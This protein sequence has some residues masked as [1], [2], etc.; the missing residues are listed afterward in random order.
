MSKKT[1]KTEKPISRKRPI[2]EAYAELEDAMDVPLRETYVI[3]DHMIPSR[4]EIRKLENGEEILAQ[5][6]KKRKR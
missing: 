1:V 4:D 2:I 6:D 3:E 5:L